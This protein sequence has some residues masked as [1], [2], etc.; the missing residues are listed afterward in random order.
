VQR[1]DGHR[2]P[3]A[4]APLRGPLYPYPHRLATY[5]PSPT[6]WPPLRRPLPSP[7]DW[8]AK[9]EPHPSLATRPYPFGASPLTYRLGAKGGGL[10]TYGLR[11]AGF[12]FRTYPHYPFGVGGRAFRP[13]SLKH[14]SHTNCP[15]KNY[16]RKKLPA[17]VF[18]SFL[19]FGIVKL[20][21]PKE[22]WPFSGTP[23]TPPLF[24]SLGEK[25]KKREG[26]R[27]RGELFFFFL[28]A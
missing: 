27:G 23:P 11:G 14:F 1:P 6:D 15:A 7:T 21:S 4:P 17:G 13:A 10:A 2:R 28:R 18:R 25:I 26:V 24:F 3:C 22:L 12:F 9:G 16:H 5:P 8:M 20:L 19:G